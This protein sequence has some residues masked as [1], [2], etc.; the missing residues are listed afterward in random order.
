M[1]LKQNA[2][3]IVTDKRCLKNGRGNMSNVRVGIIGIGNMGSAHLDC[4]YKSEIEGMRVT[5]VCDTSPERCEYVRKNYSGVAVFENDDDFFA[6]ADINAVIV[7]TPHKYH[8]ELGIIALERG[9]HL[10]VEK[11]EDVSVTN[12]RKLNM[13]AKR[14]GRVF[15]IMFNQRTNPLFAKARELV[16]SGKLGGLRRSVWIVTNWYRT[17]SYY[18]SGGWRATWDG[19]G[20]GVLLNQAPHNLD[21]WQWICG[22]PETVT[23]FCDVA[24]YHKIE[25]EDDVTIFARYPGGATGAFITSTGEFPGTNRLEISGDLGKLVLEN[26]KMKWWRLERSVQETIGESTEMSASIPMEYTEIVP[27][28][29]ETAHKGILQNF[30]DAV[31]KGTPLLAPGEEGVN[32]LMISNAAYCSSWNGNMEIKLPLDAENFDELLEQHIKQHSESKTAGKSEQNHGYSKRWQ[33]CW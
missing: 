16:R 19:E 14:S 31:R 32:E 28:T 8:A 24:K 29:P 22:M 30:S 25:V 10:L 15:G 4:I 11:P 23:A 1:I 12:A 2:V 20:G 21:L 9:F 6:N 7:A 26:G 13:A 3:K 33:V 27:D 5:A 18:N 17:Q